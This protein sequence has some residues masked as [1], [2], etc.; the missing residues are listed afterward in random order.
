[1]SSHLVFFVFHLQDFTHPVKKY[2]IS[3]VKQ[4]GL[5][6]KTRIITH[7]SVFIM[8][9]STTHT[10]I[11]NQ[12]SMSTYEQLC[13]ICYLDYLIASRIPP[14]PGGSIARNNDKV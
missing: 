10:K 4:T 14:G 3:W 13:I 7:M 8:I 9:L 11:D 5:Q 12:H 6:N 1:M 2:L